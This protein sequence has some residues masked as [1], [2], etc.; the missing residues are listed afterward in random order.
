MV[1]SDTVYAYSVG[2]VRA[3]ETRLLERSRFERMID[4]SSAD[5]ALKVLS[6]SDYAN[7][8]SELSDVHAFE[9]MLSEEL[10]KT[11]A[12]LSGIAPRPEEI[13]ILAL[14][15]DIHNLKV[16]FKEKYLGI[17]S[18]LLIDAGS[19]PVENL[20]YAVNEDYYRDLPPK[21]RD[22]AEKI[23]EDFLLNRNPQVID[24]LLDTVLFE[25][26]MVSAEAMGSDFFKQLFI[27]QIDLINLKS[28]IRVKRMRFDRDF[29][30]KVLLPQ[31]SLGID[32][33]TANL[34][35][36]LESLINALAMSEYADLAGEGLREWL[37]N[38]TA[39]RLEKLSDD[40][41][42]AYLKR[43]KWMAF[44]LEPLICYLWAK[45]IEIKNIRLVLV[46]KINKLPAE[47]IRE[48][49]RNVHI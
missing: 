17:K 33:L 34:D 3:L 9:T 36:P 49:L 25:Q 31:G 22:T 5:E 8:I 26:L 18:D 38:K 2:R 27:K 14:R 46:G 4:A 15:F 43:G 48:R 21:I 40:Y 32:R 23:N 19:L 41:I 10:K 7:A 13:K 24:L 11:F 28:L 47:A 39:S 35:E 20:Q 1:L 42:S 12:L 45:E 16:L 37:E 6:E 44:G 29:L 30:K